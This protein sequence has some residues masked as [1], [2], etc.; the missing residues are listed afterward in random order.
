M[1]QA[2]IILRFLLPPRQDAAE[3]VHPA[4]RPLY[5]PSAS[6]EAGFMFDGLGFFAS[7]SNVGRN[8]T[9]SPNLV[10]HR[11]RKP[12]PEAYLEALAL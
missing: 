2:Q 1:K 5:N 9:L 12:Y 8:Q 7:G 10:P 3:A 6:F 11:N 4:M